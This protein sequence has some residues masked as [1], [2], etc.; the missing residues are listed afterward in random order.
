[1]FGLGVQS[2][3]N[4]R[5]MGMVARNAFCGQE[6]HCAVCHVSCARAVALSSVPHLCCILALPS[7]T[8]A[9]GGCMGP[10]AVCGDDLPPEDEE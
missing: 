8:G 9:G 5:S 10:R 1:M 2:K 4:P 7:N 3:L 6:L